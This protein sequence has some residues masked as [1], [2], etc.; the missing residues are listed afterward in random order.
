MRGDI[1]M[2]RQLIAEKTAV[3]NME[4]EAVEHHL[5]RIGKRLPASLETSSLHLD[6]IRDLKRIHS[7]IAATAYPILES[8]GELRKSRLKKPAKAERAKTT[9]SEPAAPERLAAEPQAQR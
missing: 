8:A 6:V 3:R 4:I 2:A 1:A 5:A 7:H 9:A